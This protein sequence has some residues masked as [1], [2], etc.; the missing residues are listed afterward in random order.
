MGATFS[1]KN[2]KR[3][4]FYLCT[5]AVKK[6]YAHCPVKTVA[7]GEIEEAV[8]DQLRA[9]F[10]TPELVARTFREAKT[11]V[12]EEVERLPPARVAPEWK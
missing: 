12:A 3:Y 9:V 2:G 11:R 5:A 7:A 8:I 6:G 10:R 4:R 1:T